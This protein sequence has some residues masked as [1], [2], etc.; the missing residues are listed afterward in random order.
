M[1]TVQFV[2][3]Q[4]PSGCLSWTFKCFLFKSLRG[5]TVV[6]EQEQQIRPVIPASL[7]VSESNSYLRWHS[8]VDSLIDGADRKRCRVCVPSLS[9]L[10]SSHSS[11]NAW[12]PHICVTRQVEWSG[13]LTAA[14]EGRSTHIKPDNC[15]VSTIFFFKLATNQMSLMTCQKIL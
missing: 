15:C 6:T 2:K 4:P 10:I 5:H 11:D 14:G 3:T 9:S 13:W 7:H 8:L 12:A 1:K